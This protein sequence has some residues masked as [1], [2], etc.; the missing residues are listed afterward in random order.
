M[1]GNTDDDPAAERFTAGPGRY[2]CTLTVR[3][4]LKGGVMAE[5]TVTDIVTQSDADDIGTDEITLESEPVGTKRDVADWLIDEV[6]PEIMQRPS[7]STMVMS[8]AKSLQ[9]AF[10]KI[11]NQLLDRH[12]PHELFRDG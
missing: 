6:L 10:E 1:P 7:L 5:I 9:A 4:A 2:R 8:R 3:P 11:V 12:E